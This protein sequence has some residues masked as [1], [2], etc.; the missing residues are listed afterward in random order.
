MVA[1]AV[2]LMRLKNL[3]PRINTARTEEDFIACFKELE[4]VLPFS[5]SPDQPIFFVTP[6]T[7]KPRGE[8]QRLLAD[9]PV[10]DNALA[11]MLASGFMPLDNNVIAHLNGGF[12]FRPLA[13]GE[14]TPFCIDLD[15]GAILYKKLGRLRVHSL[16][17]PATRRYL[18]EEPNLVQ[19]PSLY[20]ALGAMRGRKA[21]LGGLEGN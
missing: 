12:D 6:P 17:E 4:T 13:E 20:F 19:Y 5:A 15:Y 16:S 11:F 1:S 2:E 18:R 7:L 10:T 8:W 3:A 14:E 9:L 21:Y